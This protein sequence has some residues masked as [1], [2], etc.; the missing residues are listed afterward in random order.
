M[1]T[2][3]KT[4]DEELLPYLETRLKE[5]QQEDFLLQL[6]W[7][8][9]HGAIHDWLIEQR[10]DPETFSAEARMQLILTALSNLRMTVN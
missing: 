2:N 1:A 7:S 4:I 8:E 9:M 10:L 3:S 5:Y 6:V